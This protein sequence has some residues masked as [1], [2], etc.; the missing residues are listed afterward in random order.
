MTE[1]TLPLPE[2]VTHHK[3]ETPT[4]PPPQPPEKRKRSW[5]WRI[6]SVFTMLLTF[7]II[8][9]LGGAVW[10]L[11]SEQG[12]RYA[13]ALP[14]KLDI[15]V[16]IDAKQ[17]QGTIWDGF[18]AQ[19]VLVVT[20][21]AD[22][23]ATSFQFAWQPE[24][25][26]SK[27]LHIKQLHIGDVHIDSKPTPPT[28]KG[29]PPKLP[30]TIS[31]PIT[32]TLDSLQVGKITQGK[33]WTV[34]LHRVHASYR[35]DHTQHLLNI[36]SV[37]TDWS[38]SK[39]SFQ[40][41]T[42]APYALHG[43]LA[44]KGELDGIAVDNRLDLSGSL[45]DIVLKTNIKGLGV[46][47]DADTSFHPFAPN[48]RDYVGHIK[49]QGEGINPRAFLASLPKAKLSFKANVLPEL[50]DVIGLTGDVDLHNATPLAFDREGIAVRT[51]KGNFKVNES[52]A[53][54]I[55]QLSAQLMAKGE[56]Q[57]SGGIYAQKQTMNLTAKVSN[58][59][60]Q[61]AISTQ[62]VGMLNG[63]LHATG[64]F[65][66]PQ[67]AF[68]LN[69]GR[70]DT[71]GTVVLNTDVQNGQRVV[72]LQNGEI[73]PQGGG[74]VNV[75][76]SLELFKTQKLTLALNSEAFNPA[77]L[78]PDF[79]EG[80]INGEMKLNGEIAKTAYHAE[81]RFRP[82]SLSGANLSGGGLVSF[83]QNHLSRADL[84]VQLG[85]NVLKTQG[86]FGKKDDVLKLD[87]NAPNLAQ[88]GFG[89]HGLVIAQGSVRNT[90]DSW[91][92]IEADLAGQAREF[93]LPNVIKI[94]TLDF[95]VKGA[96]EYDSPLAVALDGKGIVSG[97]TAIDDVK[98]GMNGSLRQHRLSGVGSLKLDGKP[99]T[100]NLLADGGLN[101]QNQWLGTIS[102]LDIGGALQLHLQNPMKLE[103]GETRV[104]L[105]SARW[106]ALGGGLNLISFVW[107]KQQGLTTK[108]S[109]DNA[110][111]AQL[112]NFYTP[113]IEHDLVISADW[114]LNYG[115]SPRGYLNLRQQ[116]GDII[117]PTARK[118]KLELKNFVL[119][120]RFA[121]RGILNDFSGDT[122]YGKASGDFNILQGFGGDFTH[123][124]VGGTL[125]LDV[126]E[127]NL[128]KNL[129]P[130][131]QTVK[132]QVAG[133]VAISGTLTA[134]KLNG[135]VNGENL[136]YRNHSAGIV[137]KDGTLKSRLNDRVWTVDALT[138]RR[139]G[140][141]TLSGTADYTNDT[142]KVVAD[143]VFTRYQALNQPN[144]NLTISGKTSL[145]YDGTTFALDGT[146]VTDEGKFG[147]Q[148]S[149][150]PVLDDDVVVLGEEKT[151]A[152][153]STPFKMNLVFDLND[154]FYFSG[155]GL[156]VT[157]GGK[158]T[159]TAKPQQDITGV[160]SIN[161]VRG[162]YKAYGQDLIIKKGI[163]SFVGPLDKPNLNIRA[164]RRGSQVGAGVEV[165]GNLESPRI[166][167]VANDPMSEK[168]KLS[169]LILNR[170]SSG[171]STDEAALATAAGAFL[172]GSLNDKVGLVDD[173]GLSSSQTRNAQTGEMNPAQQV[174]T[175]GKQ[176]TRDLYMGYEAGLQTSSQSVK[177]VYQLS[178]SFQAIARAGT[179]SSGGEIKYVKRFD[180]FGWRKLLID[181]EQDKK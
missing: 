151:E 114:D 37:K 33:K 136:Y 99:L 18:S 51:L 78:Y 64:T 8:G 56:L 170:A 83:E 20:D 32:A 116:A 43:G 81:M 167:L 101:P 133:V 3:P 145:T 156:N 171:S 7:A 131:G 87:L 107:D 111:I 73:R 65:A 132:G 91:T 67:V 93:N 168:D 154:K 143:V 4:T 125:R 39:G 142:P 38:D 105:S 135:T 69:T 138:F 63:Q 165:L 146:L 75:A 157:L 55:K 58:L 6:L 122:R 23:S 52:G 29:A 53:V 74:K 17:V 45:Q 16:R 24:E 104:A 96:P 152:S 50:A 94:Q 60:S 31:L 1:P 128:L 144:R 19:D 28:P 2:A 46:S 121:E 120:T 15:G 88:F 98:L 10:L 71:R 34:I 62:V 127:L 106:Q 82:S 162:R 164:E 126:A 140:T 11:A 89:I 30:E 124:P 134:P 68:Q 27:N 26:L 141:A 102:K 112:H 173:F 181:D 85:N 166:T 59:T 92:K 153:T 57:L 86:S 158:L 163:I 54:E 123:A 113:P 48:I 115:N 40:L 80:N 148:E 95:K 42:V 14:E 49:L 177:L 21:S 174:L 76:G 117:L 103:A 70:A 175:F 159:L 84:S 5:L 100:L 90:E 160:G 35:Y 108:G 12:L 66:K 79:P 13:L 72:I 130:V 97:D 169:W 22:V 137:L 36:Q 109:V 161:V 180:G 61:D 110:H 176:L 44:S 149:S 147:F 150:A 118:P 139:G 41:K 47:L 179:E 119:K 25:L 178:K 172:A 155:E 9:A 129:L 77:K